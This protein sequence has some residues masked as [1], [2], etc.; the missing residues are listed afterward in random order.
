MNK[1]ARHLSRRDMLML[2]GGALLTAP[3]C[4]GSRLFAED[5]SLLAQRRMMG[6]GLNRASYFVSRTTQFPLPRPDGTLP[7]LHLIRS[8]QRGTMTP[9]MIQPCT[10]DNCPPPP[11]RTPP[12]RLTYYK[13]SANGFSGTGY[14]NSN[15][16]ELYRGTTLDSQTYFYVNTSGPPNYKIV[17]P[18]A[19]ISGTVPDVA[20]IP[21]DTDYQIQD[22][23]LHYHSASNTTTV[24]SQRTGIDMTNSY[25]SSSNLVAS[26]AGL[27]PVKM[28][29][30]DRAALGYHVSQSCLKAMEQGFAMM[31]LLDELA[32][33]VEQE[34]CS[35]GALFCY[36]AGAII[37]HMIDAADNAIIDHINAVCGE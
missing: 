13:R 19:T 8:S 24:H 33:Q 9:D 5:K 1:S 12:P 11:E 26:V 20:S 16:S 32:R 14:V 34:Y 31:Y 3:G 18:H 35:Y 29:P 4:S 28:S 15:Y 22:F 7:L 2:T 17:R 6:S 27:N 21:P 23:V 30:Q 25:D 36:A 37:S 10:G